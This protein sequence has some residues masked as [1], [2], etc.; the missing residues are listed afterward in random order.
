[1]NYNSRLYAKA[2]TE[3]VLEKKTAADVD[4]CIANFLGLIRKNRD[5]RKLKEIVFLADK[6]I[7]QKTG[8]KKLVVESARPLSKEN[9]KLI[10]S[11]AKSKDHIER[12]INPSIVAGLKVIINDEMLLDMSFARRI[13]NILNI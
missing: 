7:G 9:E 13:K 4:K 10:G 12:K 11:F 6:M 3:A 2:F 5:Q 8:Y 1:M